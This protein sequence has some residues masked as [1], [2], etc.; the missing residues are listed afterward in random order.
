V[1]GGCR[2]SLRGCAWQGLLVQEDRRTL[3]LLLLL[4]RMG[5]RRRQQ[6]GAERIPPPPFGPST[7]AGHRRAP[8]RFVYLSF[9]PFS[10]VAPST[11]RSPHSCHPYSRP[12]PPSAV[13][14][15]GDDK[16][17]FLFDFYRTGMC[18]WV[19]AAP[20]VVSRL[21]QVSRAQPSA[22]GAA[23]SHCSATAAALEWLQ[24]SITAGKVRCYRH[25]VC[26]ELLQGEQGGAQHRISR[27]GP[28]QRSS[29]DQQAGGRVPR[30]GDGG[31]AAAHRRAPR[32]DGGGNKERA[33]GTLMRRATWAAIIRQSHGRWGV[34]TGEG[35][36]KRATRG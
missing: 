11:P 8:K 15:P 19:A 24:P 4:L 31:P 10:P 33:E 18:C 14:R 35:R 20:P 6:R 30:T 9:T 22:A 26:R 2:R 17:L 1:R 13:A 29:A 32:C 25:G 7:S 21:S 27:H 3:L 16:M 36:G 28:G 34:G 12:V 23:P 5:R